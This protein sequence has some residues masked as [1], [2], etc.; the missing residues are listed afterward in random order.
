MSH[1]KTLTHVFIL[2]LFIYKSKRRTRA[3]KRL[4]RQLAGVS[5]ACHEANANSKD[6]IRQR[7]AAVYLL[8]CHPDLGGYTSAQVGSQEQPGHCGLLLN[9][10]RDTTE[11]ISTSFHA[12]AEICHR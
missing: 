3:R 8:G 1:K 5:P 12:N 4:N 2:R 7:L 11:L 10:D 9:P 6:I